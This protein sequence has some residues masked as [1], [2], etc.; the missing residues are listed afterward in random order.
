MKREE[1]DMKE[2]F[3]GALG[4]VLLAEGGYSDDPA[5]PGGATNM[6]IE[7]GEYDRWRRSAGEAPRAIQNIERTEAA[8]IYKV[9]YWDAV[10]GD[11]LPK[12]L[13]W[14]LFDTAVNTGCGT[15]IRELQASLGVVETC[16]FDEATSTALQ[17]R[18]VD[19][20][21]IALEMLDRRIAHYRSLVT[22]NPALAKFL[23]G[24]LNRVHALRQH[25]M[26]G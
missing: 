24:W 9:N 3:D 5:D 4:F 23:T 20:S 14:A 26:V 8:D 11:Y 2:D 21:S 7:Q 18:M 12:G 16:C 1:E 10:H 19:A 6:G 13:A 25:I 15:A 22:I 17:K